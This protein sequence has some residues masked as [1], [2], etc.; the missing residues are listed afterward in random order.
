M[1]K[2]TIE[3]I[4]TRAIK[5]FEKTVPNLYSKPQYIIDNM[6]ACYTAGFYECLNNQQ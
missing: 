3:E 1:E 2:I 6:V 4:E 5:H